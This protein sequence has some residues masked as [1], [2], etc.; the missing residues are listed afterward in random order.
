MLYASNREDTQKRRPV[1]L[2]K[3]EGHQPSLCR[4]QSFLQ[5]HPNQN[6]GSSG[7]RHQKG[8]SR[9]S[10]KPLMCGPNKH[11]EDDNRAVSG[12]ECAIVHAFC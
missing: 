8:A 10:A 9:F 7:K 12:D 6:D 2:Q 5:G 11:A 3:L 4:Q 1:K